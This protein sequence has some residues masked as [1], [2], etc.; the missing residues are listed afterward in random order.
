MLCAVIGK[1]CRT[2]LGMKS[3]AVLICVWGEVYAFS[4]AI[5]KTVA[6]LSF[7]KVKAL[8]LYP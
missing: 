8:F 4:A 3:A 2:F 6:L 7:I 1:K 5:F